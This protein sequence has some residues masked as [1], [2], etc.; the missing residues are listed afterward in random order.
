MLIG[1]KFDWAGSGCVCLWWAAWHVFHA[2]NGSHVWEIVLRQHGCD[3]DVCALKLN[4][5]MHT[6][7]HILLL[8]PHVFVMCELSYCTPGKV[9]L[10]RP[11]HTHTNKTACSSS[12]HKTQGYAQ[13]KPVISV[14]VWANEWSVMKHLVECE[15]LVCYTD[16]SHGRHKT[17]L[18]FY[19]L[20]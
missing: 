2:H 15:E 12:T 16:T 5:Y 8:S 13:A 10:H 6:D 17:V 4:Q 9:H 7:T 18:I 14:C 1:K 11:S 20:Y 19:S 3:T